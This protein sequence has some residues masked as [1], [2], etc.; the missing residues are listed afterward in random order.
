MNPVPSAWG[1]QASDGLVPWRRA[2]LLLRAMT[3]EDRAWVLAALEPADRAE[4]QSLLRE[5]DD[6]GLASDGELIH[7]A[8]APQ[9]GLTDARG[10]PQASAEAR[11]CRHTAAHVAAVLTGEPDALVIRVLRIGRW[12]WRD[13][14]L[15]S[16]EPCRRRRISEAL[17][18]GD[19]PTS[20]TRLD[21]AL[22][23]AVCRAL[24]RHDA[25]VP[26]MTGSATAG[27]AGRVVAKA[28]SALNGWRRR[29]S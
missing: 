9:A 5:L 4:L 10:T 24:E 6:I 12:P 13:S 17:E 21:A 2:A 20:P 8:L 22:L 29:A 23:D 19:A 15:A 28:V 14:L 3:G 25:A 18:L 11:L 26:T 1:R 27:R 16:F 7:A